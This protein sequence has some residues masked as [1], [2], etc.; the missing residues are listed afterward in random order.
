M[1]KGQSA[2]AP[3]LLPLAPRPL[4]L[5]PL[6]SPLP[7]L[8]TAPNRRH[9]PPG[10][11]AVPAVG[12]KQW[13]MVERA[14]LAHVDLCRGNADPLELI[15]RRAPEIQP[16]FPIARK[17]PGRVGM[18]G[19][20]RDEPLPHLITAR[21]DARPDRG[22][23]ISRLAAVF[24]SQRFNPSL[25]GAGCCAPPTGV[26]RR[27]RPGPAIGE[28]NGHAISRPHSQRQ[29]WIVA[30]RNVGLGPCLAG[31]SVTD[32]G[33]MHLTHSHESF[34]LHPERT[35]ESFPA[36]LIGAADSFQRQLARAEAVLRDGRKRRTSQRGPPRLLHP[37]EV[38]ARLGERHVHEYYRDRNGCDRN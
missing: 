2:M 17:P 5:T 20:V 25:H 35:C 3:V 4:P 11:L 8:P 19:E 34:E 21:S 18:R 22:D 6:P 38:A 36:R 27:D 29:R 15:A 24:Q 12:M 33:A 30:D 13:R 16:R 28:Q 31:G 26:N 7:Y 37:R 9:Q 14:E 10:P 1:G 23:E 32:L